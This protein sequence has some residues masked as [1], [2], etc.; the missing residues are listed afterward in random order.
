MLIP[1]SHQPNESP[2]ARA[3]LRKWR[4]VALMMLL[5]GG[6]LIEIA[7][8]ASLIS[9]DHPVLV[10]LT[11]AVFVILAGSVPF[12]T[13]RLYRAFTRVVVLVTII[14]IT[15]L[16]ESFRG[17]VTVPIYY[18]WPL[19]A[20]AYL[21]TRTDVLVFTTLS[22]IGCWS[23]ADQSHLRTADYISIAVVSLVVILTVRVLAENLGATIWSLRKASRTDPLTGLL[24]RRAMDYR[25]SAELRRGKDSDQPLTV[26]VFD[27]DHFKQIND[28][29]GHAAGDAALV[30]F[31][32]LLLESCGDAARIARM[33]GEEFAVLMPG[34]TSAQGLLRATRFADLVRADRSIAGL[35]ITVSGGVATAPIRTADWDQL[36]RRADDAVYQAKRSGRDQV[37]VS[38]GDAVT[39][40]QPATGRF[41]RA[42][43]GAPSPTVA[44]G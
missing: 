9:T 5:S 42:A 4:W 29:L 6:A 22:V 14:A 12:V 35:N 44:P 16:A 37:I 15:V 19:L 2:V 26:A 23:A 24:N 1:F 31:S 8:A 40:A 3:S 20:T 43:T 18:V 41:T 17:I 36:L 11:A 34:T 30:R 27:I 32:E 33:G 39:R 7:L 25:V 28:Q 13:P 38:T 21:L 10:Q